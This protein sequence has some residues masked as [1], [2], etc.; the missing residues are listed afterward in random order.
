MI[1]VAGVNIGW[2]AEDWKIAA[3]MSIHLVAV[4]PTPL[5]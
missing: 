2:P 3:A 4:S 1:L 5:Q